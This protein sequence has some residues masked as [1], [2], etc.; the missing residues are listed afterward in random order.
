MTIWD[1]VQGIGALAGIAA[2]TLQ[3]LGTWRRRHAPRD[4]DGL[5]SL[6]D[7]AYGH[8]LAISQKAEGTP[9]LD[10]VGPDDPALLVIDMPRYARRLSDR[11]LSD[12]VAQTGYKYHLAFALGSN[13]NKSSSERDPALVEQQVKAAKEA[14]DWIKKATDRLDRIERT[15]RP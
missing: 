10:L 9:S 8:V 12:S 5:R 4:I 3:G 2:L 1:I 7:A 11:I 13:L 14:M 6:L 15:L